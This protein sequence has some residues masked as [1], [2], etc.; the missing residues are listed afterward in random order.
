MKVINVNIRG[1]AMDGIC[2][3]VKSSLKKEKPDICFLMETKAMEKDYNK[4]RTAWGQY[5]DQTSVYMDTHEGVNRK[6]GCIILFKPGLN[7]KVNKIL[8][9]GN[10][11]HLVI[12]ANIQG[13]KHI[14]ACYYGESSSNDTQSL[15]IL[16]A[17]IQDIYRTQY[18]HQGGLLLAGDFNFVTNDT[19]PTTS[20]N[21]PRTKETMLDF[22]DQQ[23]LHDLWIKTNPHDEG[24]DDSD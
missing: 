22:I 10:G 18:Q 13:V 15:I 3:L 24:N 20:T 17:L 2:N 19:D 11:S 1:F 23:Q 8:K 14:L 6:K 12:A 16:Q 7:V 4:M 9:S 5:L 21:K